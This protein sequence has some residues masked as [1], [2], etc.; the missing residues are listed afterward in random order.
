[1]GRGRPDDVVLV[2]LE[3]FRQS[4]NGA[5]SAV[6]AAVLETADGLDGY[7]GKVS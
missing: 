5:A 3:G 1:V 6:V 4:A 7:A 2:D